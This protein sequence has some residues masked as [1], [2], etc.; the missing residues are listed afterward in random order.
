MTSGG[1]EETFRVRMPIVLVSL[2]GTAVTRNGA[3]NTYD[4]P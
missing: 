1:D 3:G 4:T 2:I